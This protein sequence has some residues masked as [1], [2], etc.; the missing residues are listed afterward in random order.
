MFKK[1]NIQIK[2]VLLNIGLT[3]LLIAVIIYY[4][5]HLIE[6]TETLS[7]KTSIIKFFVP[8]LSCFFSYLALRAIKKDEELVRSADRIR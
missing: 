3:L 8:F 7:N 5:I 1:R 4:S 6:P 2:V